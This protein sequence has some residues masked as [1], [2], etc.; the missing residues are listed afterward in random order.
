[1]TKPSLQQVTDRIYVCV[2][3][4]SSKYHVELQP[5]MQAELLSSLACVTHTNTARWRV[6]VTKAY[7]YLHVE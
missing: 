6:V 1:M 2:F 3:L 5:Q 7:N 4:F